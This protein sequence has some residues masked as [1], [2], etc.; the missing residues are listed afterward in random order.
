LEEEMI[1]TT[2]NFLQSRLDTVFEASDESGIGYKKLIKLCVDRFLRDFEK[3]KFVERALLY[4][5]DAENWRKVHFKMEYTEY[6]VYFDCK[7]VIRWSFSLI[8]AV[9]IDTYLESVLNED[10]EFSYHIDTYTK[11]S[12]LEKNYPIYVFSWEKNEK[13]EKIREIL[14]E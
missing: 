13:I 10:Q 12:Y 9:A 5:P 14:K 7:K 4:Q 6:D 3:G 1:K 2:V 8:V 11:F